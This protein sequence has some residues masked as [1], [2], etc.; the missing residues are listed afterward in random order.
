MITGSQLRRLKKEAQNMR[1]EEI[2]KSSPMRLTYEHGKEAAEVEFNE[3][4]SYMSEGNDD[5]N[6]NN[7]ALGPRFEHSLERSRSVLVDD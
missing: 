2:K 7:Q 1:N 3:H 4:F 6:Q 5:T